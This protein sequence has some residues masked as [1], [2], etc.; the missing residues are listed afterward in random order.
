M[1]RNQVS[2]AQLLETKRANLINEELIRARD[3]VNAEVSRRQ[4]RSA[5]RNATVQEILAGETQRH[6]MQY[7]TETSRHNQA[8]ELENVQHNRNT[9]LEVQRHNMTV[10]DQARIQ[11]GINQ[12]QAESGRISAGAAV[13]QSQ[14]AIQ[15]SEAALQNAATSALNAQTQRLSLEENQRAN[16]AREAETNR[17]NRANEAIRAEQARA[18]TSQANTAAVVGQS[19]A[20]RNAAETGLAK[21]REAAEAVDMSINKQRNVRDWLGLGIKAIDST[22][23]NLN[24][25]ANTARQ[26]FVSLTKGG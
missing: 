22:V 13:Q 23:S 15:Q 3:A 26:W 12:F 25:T 10:E 7:E 20:E 5:E 19:T 6:N 14:A 17:T 9:E 11:L 8:V 1:T 16:L 21:T 24:T 4:A 2:Y 18:S